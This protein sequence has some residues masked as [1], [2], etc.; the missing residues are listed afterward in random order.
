LN[1]RP[2]AKRMSSLT[3]QS[4]LVAGDPRLLTGAL[5][6]L[7]F[8]PWNLPL[9]WQLRRLRRAIEVDCDARVLNAGHDVNRYGET[10]LEVGQR[11]SAFLAAWPQCLNRSH[12]WNRG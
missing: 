12:S 6:L 9:W 8:M 2:H 4:H 3:E 1:R 5:C 11:H 7:V 10:L